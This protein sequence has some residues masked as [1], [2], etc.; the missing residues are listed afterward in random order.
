MRIFR[1]T[2]APAFR[3]RPS[4]RSWPPSSASATRTWTRRW[5]TRSR[6][7]RTTPGS[8]APPTAPPTKYGNASL[9]PR[10][11]AQLNR[12][13]LAPKEPLLK[14]THTGW[15]CQSNGRIC[16]L[17]F[18]KFPSPCLGSMVAEV[19][20]SPFA[21]RTFKQNLS[22]FDWHSHLVQKVPELDQKMAHLLHSPS[23]TRGLRF[24]ISVL[25]LPSAS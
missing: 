23:V 17:F 4:W 14:K 19:S 21:G 11:G 20:I 24:V 16:Y 9:P 2:A 3:S 7:R 8:A 1:P 12:I 6:R 18:Y 15:E 13:F 10:P 25:F 5:R 22:K